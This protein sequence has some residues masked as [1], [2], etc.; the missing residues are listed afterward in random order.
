MVASRVGSCDSTEFDTD[1]E[2]GSSNESFVPPDPLE[3]MVRA[4]AGYAH[5]AECEKPLTAE[6][7]AA[8]ERLVDDPVGVFV[9]TGAA[10]GMWKS[11]K[12]AHSAHVEAWRASLLECQKRVL[13]RLD[14][15]ALEGLLEEGQH[16]DEH[17]LRDL[18]AGFPIT[19]EVGVGG[20]GVDIPGGVL[21]GGR[22]SVHGPLPLVELRARCQVINQSTLRRAL[23]RAP[24]TDADHRVAR[25][26]WQ[27]TQKDIELGR[28]GAPMELH[29]VNLNEVLLVEAFGIL[30]QHGNSSQPSVRGIHN[31]RSNLVNDCAFM[32]QKLG[33]DG[34]DSIICWVR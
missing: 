12:V 18:I 15:M 17:L 31:F 30:E 3:H 6:Q 32:P 24:R 1:A 34:F 29:K 8:L 16:A 21:S 4:A 28:A 26:V 9:R 7:I 23:R 19:G 33:Y 11:F 5:E 22:K 2:L 27:K 10:L 14:P 13:G 25:E 20:L